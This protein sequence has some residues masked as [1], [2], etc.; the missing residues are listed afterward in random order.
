MAALVASECHDN[1]SDVD[2]ELSLIR[3]HLT[4][5]VDA[6]LNPSTGMV[7]ILDLETIRQQST[8]ISVDQHLQ[9]VN[10]FQTSCSKSNAVSQPSRVTSMFGTMTSAKMH[11]NLS[12]GS[13]APSM[14]LPGRTKTSFGV[15]HYGGSKSGTVQNASGSSIKVFYDV[16]DFLVSNRMGGRGKSSLAL[17]ADIIRLIKG[18]ADFS[19]TDNQFLGTLIEQNVNVVTSSKSRKTI[20]RAFPK[21]GSDAA[22]KKRQLSRKISL[23][24]NDDLRLSA[25]A[26][27]RSSLRRQALENAAMMEISEI[28]SENAAQSPSIVSP[29]SSHREVEVDLSVEPI[30]GSAPPA[31]TA[32]SELY[33]DFD[34]IIRQLDAGEMRSWYLY[35]VKVNFILISSPPY[36]RTRRCKTTHP[37]PSWTIL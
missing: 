15:R 20:L 11:V 28:S 5:R 29:V 31:S 16:S 37:P 14:L 9:L 27:Q 6:F 23:R 17:S 33:R 25:V 3:D 35:S 12:D 13:R 26:N 2:E 24:N 4:Q 36:L 10:Q 18:T 30:L 7:S 21:T 1:D 19:P 34:S 22:D 8:L 32:I